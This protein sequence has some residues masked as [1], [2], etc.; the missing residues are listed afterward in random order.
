MSVARRSDPRAFPLLK[1][2]CVICKYVLFLLTQSPIYVL[3]GALRFPLEEENTTTYR[4][5]V[6]SGGKNPYQLTDQFCHTY[7]L[8][9]INIGVSL[10][11]ARHTSRQIVQIVASLD[12]AGS[13]EVIAQSQAIEGRGV[14]ILCHQAVERSPYNVVCI[15]FYSGIVSTVFDYSRS[16][17]HFKRIKWGR[18]VI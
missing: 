14:T 17:G 5:C 6:E 11:L 15:N 10:R 1:R 7:L 13:V 18:S 2:Y 16:F 4:Q 9:E 8:I 3:C 12:N